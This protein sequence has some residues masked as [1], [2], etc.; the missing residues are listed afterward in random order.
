MFAFS[1]SLLT[2]FIHGILGFDMLSGLAPP[3]GFRE[4]KFGGPGVV[5]VNVSTSI[6]LIGSNLQ[7]GDAIALFHDVFCQRSLA[8]Q[9]H[10]GITLAADPNLQGQMVARNLIVTEQAANS[11]VCLMALGTEFSAAVSTGVVIRA[12]SQSMLH[13]VDIA[14]VTPA[15]WFSDTNK[16][17]SITMSFGGA[18]LQDGIG[19]KITNN[20]TCGDDISGS[21]ANWVTS[22]ISNASS[23]GTRASSTFIIPSGLKLGKHHLEDHECCV[24]S[25]GVCALNSLL[26]EHHFN[27]HT[28]C[29]PSVT[30]NVCIQVNVSPS[31]NKTYTLMPTSIESKGISSD[32]LLSNTASGILTETALT[33]EVIEVTHVP[34]QVNVTFVYSHSLGNG[35]IFYV[36]LPDFTGASFSGKPVSIFSFMSECSHNASAPNG[37][38]AV[39]SWSNTTNL[40][41]V[42]MMGTSTSALN[43]LA[44]MRIF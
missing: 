30:W 38:H 24:C 35:D 23:D 22:E 37:T 4:I 1:V 7:E 43:L 31:S 6:R 36:R 15:N 40:L 13:T 5:A 10:N 44:S 28:P 32:M 3:L 41:D 12:V 18:G 8:G 42:K 14:S 39:A 2:L 26:C 21:V 25:P 16:V 19:V 11:F 33:I 20:D 29:I 34:T 27:A 9:H 17:M